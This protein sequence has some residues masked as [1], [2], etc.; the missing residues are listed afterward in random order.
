MALDINNIRQTTSEAH[1]PKGPERFTLATVDAG[2]KYWIDYLEKEIE[3]QARMGKR[4]AS[5][6][7]RNDFSVLTRAIERPDELLGDSD[8]IPPKQRFRYYSKEQIA[9][10]TNANNLADVPKRIYQG[11]HEH[12]SRAGFMVSIQYFDPDPSRD[13]PVEPAICVAW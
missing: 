12:F 7:L 9:Y 5:I 8:W 13:R 4:H 6:M 1:T 11:I 10:S 3:R 2:V